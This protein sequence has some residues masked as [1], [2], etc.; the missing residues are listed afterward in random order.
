MEVNINQRGKAILRPANNWFIAFSLLT[1]TL[2]EMMPIERDW[3]VPD[4]LGLTLIFW[5]IRQ[6]R[7]VGMGM[8]WLLG[9]VM[10]VHS[11]S[12]FGEHSLAYTLMAYWAITIHRRVVWFSAGLQALHVLPL[13]LMA[14]AVIF[15]LR[16]SLGGLNPGWTFFVEPLI[17]AAIWPVL[18]F[19]LLIPQRLPQ[20]RDK[21]RPI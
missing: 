7:V 6:P 17:T 15:L 13:L 2:L 16:I 20:T 14:Q 12:V 3:I 18:Q 10:D 9:M 8:A 4:F 1:A 19:L 5:N 11:A 21:N